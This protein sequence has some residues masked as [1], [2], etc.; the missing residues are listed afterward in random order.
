MEY[1]SL[2]TLVKNRRSIRRFKKDPVPKELILKIVEVAR[3]APSGFNLQPW[4]FVIV[5]KEA[6]R[7]QIVKIITDFWR[8]SAEMERARPENRGRTWKLKGI[9]DEKNDYTEAPVYILICGDPRTKAGLPMG[10]Q[11]DRH[12]QETIY[13]SGLANTFLYMTLAATALDLASQWCS[14]VQTPYAS[15]MI[16]D[17]LNIPMEFDIYDML[18]LGYPAIMPPEKFLRDMDKMIH[19]NGC[20]DNDLRSDDE[21]KAFVLKARNWN[22]GAHSR[23]VKN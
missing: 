4:E 15:C 13:T 20:S 7:E 9:N 5:E 19:W 2:L 11:C 12:R 14:A 10:V 18:I 17:L 3:W 1:D 23:K 8:Q 21:T 22:I 6:L 16:K